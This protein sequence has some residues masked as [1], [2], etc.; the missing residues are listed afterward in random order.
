M[1]RLELTL[2]TPA[3]N[4]ALDE[5]LLDWAEE[6]NREWEFLRLW[7]SPQ[8]MVVVGRSSRV[9]DEVY[10]S[11]CTEANVPILRRS[12]GG[13]AIVAG[14]GCLMYA[15]VLGYRL[16]PELKD[17]GRAHAYVLGRLAAALGPL[18]SRSGSVAHVGTSDLVL[19]NQSGERR[20][21]SGNSMRAKRTHLVYHGTLLY[22]A[23]LSLVAR[24]LRMPPRQPEYRAARS[25]ADFLMNLPLD[26]REVI[27]AIDRAWPTVG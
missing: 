22:D 24:Y 18:V 27:S 3:E 9:H 4:L 21:F 26:R 25:H 20:K 7:E 6:T 23:D 17:I 12:S 13:A 1:R 16:R 14:P 11:A 8:P 15:V 19:V 5:A 2:P 10:E